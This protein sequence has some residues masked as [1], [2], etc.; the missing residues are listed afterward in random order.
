M[1]LV[2]LRFLATGSF[3]QVVGD[4]IGI[5][6]STASRIVNKVTRALARLR[7]QLINMPSTRDEISRV[8][9]RFYTIARF[10]NCIG[11][12]DCTHVKIQSPGGEQAELFRNRKQYFAYNVQAVCDASLK[13]LDIVCKWPGSAH[14]SIIFAI[15]R[16]RASLENF[17]FGDSVIV[18]DSGYGIKPYL[19]TPLRHPETQAENLFNESQIRTRNPIERG[20]RVLKRRFPILALGIRLNRQ[21]VEAVVLASAVLHNI[22]IEMGETIEFEYDEEVEAEIE[23]AL[24]INPNILEDNRD[25]NQNNVVRHRLILTI[26]YFEQLFYLWLKN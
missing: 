4:F 9:Q 11:A 13:F 23:L 3:L 12:L 14:D 7:P 2:T 15:S 5:D 10:P 6:K 1:V 17:D 22:A 8:K 21:K 18:G 26:N 24:D 25:V 19:I 20:F 16:I